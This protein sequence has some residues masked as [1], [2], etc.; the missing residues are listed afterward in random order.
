[1]FPK[2]GKLF[3]NADRTTSAQSYSA[4]V[5]IALKAELGDTHRA[6]K[7]AM[8]WTG[9]SDRTVKHW[10]SGKYGPSGEHLMALARHSD[11]VM[12]AIV[13]LAGRDSMAAE[14]F[15]VE[16]R[17]KLTELLALLD[18]RLNLKRRT[19]SHADIEQGRV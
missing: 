16:V 10:L 6:V 19:A 12:L 5:A 9:A 3:P 14:A 4:A 17:Q 1:M 13:R 7:T 2:K 18:S 15:D 11:H 8:R